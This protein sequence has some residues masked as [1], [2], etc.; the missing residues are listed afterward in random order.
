MTSQCDSV[1]DSLTGW[2]GE[3]P[4][5]VMEHV[6]RCDSCHTWLREVEEVSR[7]V[8]TLPEPTLER[9]EVPRP[10]ASQGL[11]RWSLQIVRAAGIAF[12]IASLVILG[13]HL[14]SE[15]QSPSVAFIPVYQSVPETPR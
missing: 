8:R 1:R 5:A 13:F 15:L 12:V 3:D 4:L 7:K 2:I 11:G 14:G 9:V 6:S 10:A